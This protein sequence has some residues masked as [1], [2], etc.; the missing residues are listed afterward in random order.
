M[1]RPAWRAASYAPR[2]C[3][4]PPARMADGRVGQSEQ[5]PAVLVAALGVDVAEADQGWV[6]WLEYAPVA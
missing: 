2:A 4:S 5:R 3:R 6:D 1:R